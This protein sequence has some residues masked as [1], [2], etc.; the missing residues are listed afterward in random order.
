MKDYSRNNNK[1]LEEAIG[2]ILDPST[3]YPLQVERDTVYA[4]EVF[5]DQRVWKS[6]QEYSKTV[7][8]Y[9]EEGTLPDS[10]AE[11][12]RMTVP[13]GYIPEE[14]AH[15]DVTGIQLIEQARL[16]EDSPFLKAI[17]SH[18][19]YKELPGF[20]KQRLL[21]SNATR[22]MDLF[23]KGSNLIKR[24]KIHSV[25]GS[26]LETE[27]AQKCF[28]A[29]WPAGVNLYSILREMY[30][31]FHSRL[32]G[33]IPVHVAQRLKSLLD[34]EFNKKNIHGIAKYVV[35][36]NGRSLGLY[37]VAEV[38]TEQVA[39][40]SQFVSQDQLGRRAIA[41]RMLDDILEIVQ[42]QNKQTIVVIDYAGGVGN[43]SEMLLKRLYALPEGEVKSRLMNQLRTVVID[44]AD[45]QLAA[46]QNRFDQMSKHQ[47][48]E[49][50]NDKIIFLKG[51]VTR[52]LD[53]EHLGKMREK[54]TAAFMTN[55]VYLGMTSYTLGA[56]DILPGENG[57][58]CAHAMADAM[59]KQCWE[60]YAV[61][62][63]SP[64]WRVTDFL[65]DTG[66]WGKEYL[67]TIHGVADK[68]DENT[69]LHWIAAKLLKLRYGLT[70]NSVADF[71]KFMATGPGLASHYVTTWPGT[72]GH[73][74]GYSV[75]EDGLLKKPSILSFAERLQGYGAKVGYKSKVWLFATHDIGR[76]SKDTRAWA[77]MPG[78]V[79]DFVVVQN[80]KNSPVV[81]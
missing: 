25:L 28:G 36:E 6:L 60:I 62:F 73:N 44:V 20:E 39:L 47:K 38:L 76:T 42:I 52:P 50:I 23:I 32:T 3:V 80:E 41:K 49:G 27:I 10:V 81:R 77:F 53:E 33:Q 24:E 59:F 16:I 45:D 63:S 13:D 1:M 35:D 4:R 18:P 57:I 51:D 22:E 71:V 37:P 14:L 56:L 15:Q 75:L 40:S 48:L 11:I 5:H 7:R 72:Y 17:S 68:E 8:R 65:R 79:A 64:M 46:G 55:P 29:M 31:V 2:E 26:P 69:P 9:E 66:K 12:N 67:R 34:I 43:I 54:Y 70:F 30:L 74:S 78:W 21:M 58:T 61:D 19:D